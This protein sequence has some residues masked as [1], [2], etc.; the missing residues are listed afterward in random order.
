MAVNDHRGQDELTDAHF[1][2]MINGIR[3]GEELHSPVAEINITIASLQLAN[4]SWV[5]N[6]ELSLDTKTG[7]VMNNPEAM[8]LWSR[9]YE[10]GW[11]VTV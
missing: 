8:K 5:V 7:H 1:R 3:T 6:G 4:I 10:K 2:N 9:Q 11:E